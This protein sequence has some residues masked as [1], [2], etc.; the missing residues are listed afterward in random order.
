MMIRKMDWCSALKHILARH[1]AEEAPSAVNN[2]ALDQLIV[3]AITPGLPPL[4]PQ[5]GPVPVVSADDAIINRFAP[6][7]VHCPRNI[8]VLETLAEAYARKR[9]FDQ[10]LSFY[11][12]ALAIAGGKNA[13]IEAAIEATTLKRFDLELSQLDPKA[14]DQAVQRERIQNQRLDYQWHEME[15]ASQRDD[16][17]GA[18][19]G[20]AS[21][22]VKTASGC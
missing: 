6:L 16:Q 11:R 10:S 1:V 9:M 22:E 2:H 17:Q 18:V 20:T 12:R 3:S 21:G 19:S 4:R 5:H 8:K 7:L 13:A 15:E 14:S